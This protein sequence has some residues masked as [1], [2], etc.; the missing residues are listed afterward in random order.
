MYM[1]NRCISFRDYLWIF[2]VVVA[3]N[4]IGKKKRA[5][6][7]MPFPWILF[8]NFHVHRF[9]LHQMISNRRVTRAC[10]LFMVIFVC[11]HTISFVA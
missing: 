3:A 1:T 6:K 7:A 11:K 4:G 9:R 8:Y 2:F 5:I 10:N